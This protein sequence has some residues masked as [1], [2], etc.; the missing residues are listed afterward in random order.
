MLEAERGR[1][2]A[3][4]HGKGGVNGL[5]KRDFFCL[6]H[7]CG[8]KGEMHKMSHFE[9][10]ET[11]LSEQPGDRGGGWSGQKQFT[12]STFPACQHM[13]GRKSEI[14]ASKVGNETPTQKK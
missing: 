14:S 3:Q 12:A 5:R 4:C 9:I 6:V 1:I 7:V 8:D 2:I 13:G 11:R 10:W